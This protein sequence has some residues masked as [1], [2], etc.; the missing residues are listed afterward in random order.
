MTNFLMKSAVKKTALFVGGMI[1]GSV[2]SKAVACPCFKKAAVK[3]TAVVLKAKDCILD[4][5]SKVQANVEDVI[6]EAKEV[7]ETKSVEEVKV[8]TESQP[9]A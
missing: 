1:A 5:V 8:E 4:K 2:S 7:N 6:A 3:T 9:K